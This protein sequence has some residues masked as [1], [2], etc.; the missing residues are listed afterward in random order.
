M[1]EVLMRTVQWVAR[2]VGVALD[3]INLRSDFE[4]FGARRPQ[5]PSPASGGGSGNGT[6]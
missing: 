4:Q 3:Y 6:C 1:D 2:G 5:E